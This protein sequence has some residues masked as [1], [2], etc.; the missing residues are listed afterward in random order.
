MLRDV[1]D[2]LQQHLPVVCLESTIITHGMDYPAN[3]RMARQVE[4]VIEDCGAVPAT[5]AILNGVPQIGL[6]DADLEFLARTGKQARK[7]SR[8]DMAA[9]QADLATG[10]TT[11][12]GTMIL[13]KK[14]GIDVF[15]TGGIG[16]VHRG[17]AT[18]MDVSNDLNELSKNDVAVICAG[19]KAILD[20]PLSLEYLETMGVTVTTIGQT[21]LPAFYSRDSGLKSPQTSSTVEDAAK[22]INANQQL[23]L[24]SSVLVCV[25]IPE[26]ASIDGN[27]MRLVIDA[28]VKQAE[29]Q[30][31][32]GKDTTPFLLSAVSKATKGRSLEANIRLVMENARI[33]AQIAIHL[34]RLKSES[35][36]VSSMSSRDVEVP[37]VAARLDDD[38]SQYVARSLQDLEDGLS[39]HETASRATSSELS[40][41]FAATMSPRVMVVGGV[42][43]DIACNIAQPLTKLE[44]MLYTSN[45][46]S[47]ERSV[48]GVAGN[49]ARA[50]AKVGL[51]VSLVSIFGGSASS[52]SS[53]SQPDIDAKFILD[54]LSDD[55]V[56]LQMSCTPDTRTATYTVVQA[57]GELLVAVADMEIFEKEHV[58]LMETL[59]TKDFQAVIFDAN[60]PQVVNEIAKN[61]ARAEV[62]C[63][64]PTS[65]PKASRIF[66]LG[67]IQYDQGVWPS[68]KINL[69]T[70]NIYELEAMFSSA[71]RS[72]QFEQQRWWE[73]INSLNIAA[74][75]RGKLEHFIRKHKSI[76]IDLEQIGAV[77]QAIHLL[78]FFEN[79]YL[80]MGGSGVLS[81]HLRAT[82]ESQFEHKNNVLAQRSQDCT[83]YIA[84]HAALKAPVLV[85]DSGA[86]DTFTGVLVAAL[87][88]GRSSTDSVQM[89]QQAAI[90]TLGS[91]ESVSPQIHTL[92]E[93]TD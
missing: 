56:A 50:V 39:L 85:S 92:F 1:Q 19:P 53:Q 35:R 57:K 44:K 11:V 45:P 81:F 59:I 40:D 8:R 12:S 77:Q 6:E 79:I 76:R 33:G 88:Q 66:D 25:P 54:S 3:L 7:V 89:A 86:G 15:V 16:G 68:N 46:G 32:R 82:E 64:E 34:A 2:A 72:G 70:P 49:I 9:C 17:A 74:E 31:I 10:G 13:A 75:F 80:T 67:G 21:N 60:I 41:D 42:A 51:N 22:L 30:G 36:S 78:P 38:Q 48:G 73:V 5:I 69:T 62:I 84:Y 37:P 90:L 4:K 43:V 93:T 26:D 55:N 18:T 52:R 63:F 20:I 87:V 14:A 83:V 27:E 28:A 47:V 29:A 24:G 58:D 71:Q 91:R 23:Q 61:G 65:V